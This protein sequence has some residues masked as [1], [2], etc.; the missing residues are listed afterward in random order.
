MSSEMKPV[1][2]VKADEAARMLAISPRALWLCASGEIP[3]V[4]IGKSERF[5]PDDLAAWIASR[6][7]VA[8]HALTL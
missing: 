1:L 5:S 7:T 2:L 3:H 4:R 8:S 6:K